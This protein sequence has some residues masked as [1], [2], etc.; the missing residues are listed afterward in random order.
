MQIPFS[1]Y[2][3]RHERH[4]RRKL[5]NPL[6]PRPIHDYHDDALLEEQRMDHEEIVSFLGNLRTLVEQAVSLK[7]NEESDIVLDLKAELE[8][9]YETSCRLGDQQANNKAAIRDLL[10]VIM[11]T[12]R[13]HAGGDSKAEQ[14]LFQEE[15]ARQQHFAM[16]EYVLVADLI[17]P[18]SLILEDELAAVMLSEDEGQVKKALELLDQNQRFLLAEQAQAILE[19]QNLADS[20]N[21]Q[22]RITLMKS[23]VDDN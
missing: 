12:V 17:D 23:L 6:Y 20:N 10:K 14:E 3:G 5:N 21:Y 16:L 19:K 1:E 15:M 11:A 2:P 7:P 22:Q 8:K 13:S 18:E 9:L 4:F